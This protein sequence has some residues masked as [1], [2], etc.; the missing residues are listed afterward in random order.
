MIIKLIILSITIFNSFLS[1]FLIFM[2][3][4]ATTKWLLPR[5]GGA[6]EV[7][8]AA[9][10]FFQVCL[11]AGYS[12]V[13]FLWDKIR[14]IRYQIL[15]HTTLLVIAI[16]WTLQ[17]LQ[18]LTFNFDS[19][20]NIHF[21]ALQVFFVLIQ[22]FGIPFFVITTTAPILQKWFYLSRQQSPY[23]LYSLS[24]VG[25][26][27]GLLAYPLF[28]ER[29]LPIHHQIQ[30]WA[31]GFFILALLTILLGIFTYLSGK[32]QNHSTSEI[33]ENFQESPTWQSKI[34]WIILAF[35]PSSLM[36]GITLHMTTDLAA[37]P[38]L[39]I[40]PLSIYLI[41][42]IIS[43]S[44][45]GIPIIRFCQWFFPFIV[46]PIA[47]Q[48][49]VKATHPIW[50]IFL[51]QIV[52]FFV[53]T[54]V[55]H[56]RVSSM[57]PTSQHLTAYYFYLSLGGALGGMFNALAAP[58]LFTTTFEYPLVIA[59]A[60]VFYLTPEKKWGLHDVLFGSLMVGSFILGQH[61]IVPFF[62][63][64]TSNNLLQNCYLMIPPLIVF[65]L[66]K[67]P[68]LLGI[69]IFSLI[70]LWL[71][72][73]QK[74]TILLKK[75]NF[76]GLHQVST[77]PSGKIHT[78]QHGT[79]FH[80]FQNLDS[81]YAREPMGYYSKQSP[82]GAILQETERLI[83]NANIGLVGLGAGVL[84]AYSAPGQNWEIIE[85]DSLV[86]DIAS[87]P[88]YFTYLSQ[89][90]A[91]YQ[92]H[93]GDGRFKLV[94][95]SDESFDILII[96][97]FTSDA[98]PVHLLTLEAIQVYLQKIKPNGLIV[99]HISNRYLKLDSVLA[100]SAQI[101]KL[102]FYYRYHE[103][104]DPKDNPAVKN[105]SSQWAVLSNQE[106][107]LWESFLENNFKDNSQ[108]KLIDQP[109]KDD[110]S[111]LLEVFQLDLKIQSP[112]SRKIKSD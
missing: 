84:L 88:T 56:G 82:I 94:E 37:I 16:G 52:G 5:F 86:K 67:K 85:I 71:S 59:L 100:K 66:R 28:I 50:L 39:W 22:K 53:I 99:F 47:I 42:F 89:T 109:W 87:N 64:S 63:S 6:P 29:A 61:F 21:Q 40:I 12:Y 24:N 112:F 83:P 46:I 13:H 45:K 70:T 26:L 23:F 98:I 19:I 3:E 49:A 4:P 43:F 91:P 62:T 76:F 57:K 69:G 103:L 35:I 55:L 33:K 72:P 104:E 80:G 32:L 78:Y 92:I 54:T 18:D 36:S 20:A 1:S 79:T 44:E 90:K 17:H 81:Q 102:D 48:L 110:Y 107:T 11:L 74:N 111:N 65:G 73:I 93:V 14:N 51:M 75:R 101:Q 7:W 97:A 68:F 96:D 108:T 106:N 95:F 27:G 34:L 15:F 41:S 38:L 8:N 77:D 58:L 105:S 31:V 9:V 30:Y 60:C 10:V 2:I 25:S